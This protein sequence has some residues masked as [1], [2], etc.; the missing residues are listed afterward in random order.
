MGVPTLSLTQESPSQAYCWEKALPTRKKIQTLVE[1]NIDPRMI[2]K[3]NDGK[4]MIINGH[5]EITKFI[6]NLK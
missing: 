2:V 4:E 1:A 5:K 3:Y 6:E